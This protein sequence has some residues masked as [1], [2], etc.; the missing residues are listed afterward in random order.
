M[1]LT[2]ATQIKTLANGRVAV[3]KYGTSKLS[4]VAALLGPD[5]PEVFTCGWLV[6]DGHT[7]DGDSVI[8]ACSATAVGFDNGWACEAGHEHH[9]YGGPT[10]REYFDEEEMAG[11]R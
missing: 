4:S 10:H 5:S 8:I 6:Q 2:D 11:R 7:E 1:F 9:T 3:I